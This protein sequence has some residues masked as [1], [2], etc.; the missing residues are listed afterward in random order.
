MTLY[1]NID[2]EGWLLAE[3]GRLD[4]DDM[5]GPPA[6]PG[7]EPVEGTS[8]R[9]LAA[10]VLRNR[11]S[12][13]ARARWLDTPEPVWVETATLDDLKA[14]AIT[15]TYADVDK[16]HFDA[17]GNRATEYQDAERAARAFAADSFQ[18]EAD[19]DVHS[20]ALDNT[21]GEVQTDQW[22]AES[23]IARADAFRAAQKAMRNARFKRQSE[24]R[25]AATPEELMAVAAAWDGFI[26]GLRA[27]LG[28]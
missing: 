1:A 6:P 8:L 9:Q 15:K 14:A 7:L 20:Y 21:T 16:V 28:L 12:P 2:A 26:A 18:G 11:P 22:A 10:P 27:Q 24:M 3:F 17:V 25:A 4:A 19:D 13:T 5:V 23:I